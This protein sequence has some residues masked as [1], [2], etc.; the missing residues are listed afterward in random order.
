MATYE[1]DIEN[2]MLK[3]SN[4]IKS[5]KSLKKEKSLPTDIKKI[6]LPTD[7]SIN[8]LGALK[9]AISIAQIQGA[10]LI[11]LHVFHMPFADEHMPPAMIKELMNTQKERADLEMKT[12]MESEEI[13]QQN[14]V[15]IEFKTVMGFASEMILVFARANNVDLIITGTKG[16]NSVDD[17]LFGTVTWNIIKQSEIPVIAI[18]EQSENNIFKNIMIPFEGTEKDN[19]TIT[20][21][22]NF[23]E[24]NKATVHAVHFLT[25]STNYNKSM[26]DKLHNRFRRYLDN[27]MLQLHFLAEKNITEGIKKFASRN[28][29]DMI[30]MVT[31]HHGLFATIFHMSITRNIALYSQIPLLAY[32]I[33]K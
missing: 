25:D 14:M 2:S 20:W 9:S 30:S 27:D 33:D 13:V 28:N 4:D 17:K 18:P 5:S 11:V 31:H 23:A 1:S 26:I 22:L 15:P 8:S 3:G 21:L 24:K 16:A 29:I 19:D 7:Y 32:N 10:T 6:L 12:F